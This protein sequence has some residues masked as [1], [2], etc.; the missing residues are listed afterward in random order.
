MWVPRP[1]PAV[2][3]VLMDSDGHCVTGGRDVTGVKGV[4]PKG[5]VFLGCTVDV[6][7]GR[8]SGSVPSVTEDG[9]RKRVLYDAR[10]P[11]PADRGVG[12]DQTRSVGF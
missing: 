6:G 8:H 12:T 5:D 1:R 11:S 10:H 7:T 9:G 3:E 4:E 2:L